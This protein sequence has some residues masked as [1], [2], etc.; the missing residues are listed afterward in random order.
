MA[1]HDM[2]MLKMGKRFSKIFPF[3]IYKL[4]QVSS[5]NNLAM[6][7]SLWNFPLISGFTSIIN[8]IIFYRMRSEFNIGFS[9]SKNW[10][11]RSQK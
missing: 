11:S 10:E 6:I 5:G 7:H 9:I 4:N 1:S 3:N 2:H 8:L